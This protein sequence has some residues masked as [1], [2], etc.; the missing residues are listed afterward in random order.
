V[1][2]YDIRKERERSEVR[3]KEKD[4]KKPSKLTKDR[5]VYK[6][7]REKRKFQ[8]DII[9]RIKEIVNEEGEK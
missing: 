3:D 5:N 9:K 7:R 2:S 6:D 8:N 4:W 1:T